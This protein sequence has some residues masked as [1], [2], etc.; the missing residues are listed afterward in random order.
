VKFYDAIDRYV[1]DMVA[2]GR[3]TSP[4]TVSS[5]RRT[6][7]LHAADVTNRDPR[8]V[9][10]E[11]V[12]RTLARWPNPSTRSINRA[13]LVAFYR[14]LLQE[15]HRKDNPAEATR[16]SR[17]RP[18]PRR[19]L[20]REEAVAMLDAAESQR[21]I[22]A[23]SLLMCAG[24]RRAEV[25][26]LRGEHFGRRDCVRVSPEI[27]KGSRERLVPLLPDLEP[28]AEEIRRTVARDQYVLPAQRW[29]DP[30]R[31]RMKADLTREPASPQALGQLIAKVSRRA[32]ISGR[33]TAHTLRHAF[34]D[35]IAKGVDTHTAQHLLGHADIGTTQIYLSKPLFDELSAAVKHLSFRG[36]ARTNVLGVAEALGKA[37]EAT[38]GIEP[39]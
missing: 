33:I 38:T 35:H 34:A 13:H 2:E 5:Y 11:D 31:N 30:G 14:W 39:V 16:P 3:F 6:L 23:V 8:Y 37:L 20:T 18:K 27:A 36:A 1:A 7:N 22:W 26:G 28:V 9:G 24:L 21:E 17:R 32:G 12:H 19:R 29:R 4:R 25:L 15:G 10:R